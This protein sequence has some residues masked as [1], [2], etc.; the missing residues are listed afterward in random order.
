MVR[1]R[2]KEWLTVPSLRAAPRRLD[3]G[4]K[5]DETEDAEEVPSS[6]FRRHGLFAHAFVYSLFG[7]WFVGKADSGV[8]HWE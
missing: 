3:D 6:G 5:L 4:V 8:T 2:R 1:R 7:R